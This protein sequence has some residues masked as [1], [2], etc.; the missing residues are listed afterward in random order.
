MEDRQV[1]G[2]AEAG[3]RIRAIAPNR[4][5]VGKRE[6]ALGLL[7]QPAN[8]ELA[9]REQARIAGGASGGFDLHARH[10]GS[11]Q[12]GFGTTRDD[13][14]PGMLVGATAFDS[15]GW[16]DNW[17]AALRLPGDDDRWWIVAMRGSLIYEDRLHATEAEAREALAKSLEAPDWEKVIAPRSWE[18]AKAEHAELGNVLSLDSAVR[19]RRVN[20][21]SRALMTAAAVAAIALLL[22]YGW[23]QWSERRQLALAELQESRAAPEV[24][25]T[26]PWKH[27]PGVPAFIEGCLGRMEELV[28]LPPGWLIDSLVCAWTGKSVTASVVWQGKSGNPALLR[29]AASGTEGEGA[30]VSVSGGRAELVLPVEL[31][32]AESRPPGEPWKLARLETVI[33]ERFRSLGLDV[34]IS[35]RDFSPDRSGVRAFPRLDLGFRTSAGIEEYGLLLSDLPALVPEALVY[36]PGANIWQL[37]VKAYSDPG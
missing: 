33:R 4:I 16:G 11:R 10:S 30:G 3:G 19:L 6:V 21:E 14:M 15:G 2:A 25:R 31:G 24:T 8:P 34:A 26:F 1:P 17:L 12:I 22:L 7:W 13:L 9:L 27:A 36:R 28:I 23:S 29:A 32:Q 20:W 35:R 37:T 5:A 18:F